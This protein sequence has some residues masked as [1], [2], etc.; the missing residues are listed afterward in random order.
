MTYDEKPFDKKS[1][2]A[3]LVDASA[4][5]FIDKPSKA[6]LDGTV[7]D[8]LRTGLRISEIEE[9]L[10]ELHIRHMKFP[11]PPTLNTDIKAYI[12]RVRYKPSTEVWVS[13]QAAGTPA[14]VEALF[15][16]IKQGKT[17]GVAFDSAR[18]SLKHLTDDEVWQCYESWV[19]GKVNSLLTK[20][21]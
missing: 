3:R 4:N 12:A 8:L 13:K 9:I 17:S 1:E 2:I 21:E 11:A 10:K 7:E 19:Q 14:S 5:R 20:K 18:R 16:F 6:F 15:N